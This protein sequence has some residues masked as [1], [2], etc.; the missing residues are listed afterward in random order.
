MF[1]YCLV[2]KGRREYLPSALAS[3]SVALQH[4]D[5]QVI[6]I[7]NG[8]PMDVSQILS[9]WCQSSTNRAFYVRFDVNDASAP[10]VWDALEDFEI[11]WI[12]FP[13]DDDVVR[14]EFL[15]SARAVI[16]EKP[17]LTALASSMRIIDSVG[18]PIGQ[19]REP[20]DYFED[21]LL[22]LAESI[23]EPPFQFPALFFK[24]KS[25]KTPLPKSRYIFD[26]WIS[27]NLITNGNFAI[28]KE[29]S[30]DY[31]VHNQQESAV[32]PNRR[33]YFEAQVVLSRFINS[34]LFNEYLSK[35]TDKEKLIFWQAI[36][37]KGPIY[38]DSEFGSALK[39][40]I[41]LKLA[42]STQDS[43]VAG[44]IIGRYAA[45]KGVFLQ[46]DGVHC[47]LSADHSRSSVLPANF[48]IE[49]AEGS[50]AVVSRLGEFRS[51]FDASTPTFFIGCTHAT[52]KSAY[53]LNCAITDRAD[54]EMLDLILVKITAQLEAEDQFEFKIT[55]IERTFVLLIR[56]VK[57]RLPKSLFDS[58]KKLLNGSM[59]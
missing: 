33:K 5:V 14:P 28:S 24:F 48:R 36:S 4:E 57:S 22:Y 6:I 18:T 17:E 16:Q 53:L 3:L 55:P 44:E 40:E 43:I 39:L 58:S 10:R 59:K 1:T 52:E 42:D 26:W 45:L 49:V 25:I 54:S 37:E 11:D 9:E 27:L 19:L 50:C 13:G 47:F 41:L 46:E 38:G 32:A 56:R 7:D 23:H 31:R 2:T 35:L 51:S 30:I 34:Q 20:S 12:T 29:I 21:D 8:C 15:V